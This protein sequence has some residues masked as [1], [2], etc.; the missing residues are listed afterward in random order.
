MPKNHKPAYWM[1]IFH[2]TAYIFIRNTDGLPEDR[3]DER[4]SLTTN[5][6]SEP[7]ISLL[8]W[9]LS[10]TTDQISVDEQKQHSNNASRAPKKYP[11]VTY[12]DVWG[13]WLNYIYCSSWLIR[14]LLGVR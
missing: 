2:S 11:I 8:L 6:H 1:E 4:Q 12:T 10:L 9:L 14:V 13:T 3:E 7:Q 5:L